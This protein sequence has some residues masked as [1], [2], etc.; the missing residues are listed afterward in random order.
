MYEF[1]QFGVGFL[2]CFELLMLFRIAFRIVSQWVSQRTQKTHL[3]RRYFFHLRLHLYKNITGNI[4][5]HTS[6][7]LP[8]PQRFTSLLL[9]VPCL[10]N[11]VSKRP[12]FIRKPYGNLTEFDLENT[13]NK[14][15]RERPRGAQREGDAFL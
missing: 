8:A 7:A 3:T 12:S 1:R 10:A 9:L 5:F 6:A 15:I 14:T 4:T 2:C 13:L 11:L